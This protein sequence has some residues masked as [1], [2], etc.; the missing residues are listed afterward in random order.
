VNAVL[1]IVVALRAA[2]YG[3]VWYFGARVV[4]ITNVQL[5]ETN[6]ICVDTLAS[7]SHSGLW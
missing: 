5:F 7:Y 1:G 3:S 2:L 6:C 4:F